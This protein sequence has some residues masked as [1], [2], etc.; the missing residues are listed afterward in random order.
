M[1]LWVAMLAITTFFWIG[2]PIVFAAITVALVLWVRWLRSDRLIVQVFRQAA[3][4]DFEGAV[5][6]LRRAA[7]EDDPRGVRLEALGFL[8]FQRARWPEAADA[9]A[10]S[11]ER[12]A[13]RMIRRVYQAHA[14][15]KSGR[16]DEATSLLAGLSAAAPQD[17]SP[18]CGMAMVLVE[19]GNVAAA[20]EQYW[21]A[22]QILQQHSAR[23]TSDGMGLLEQCAETISRNVSLE[24]P[25][26]DAPSPARQ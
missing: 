13:T 23:Q 19:A 16:L 22:R 25:A 2:T 11:A 21:K 1:T 3:E 5:A 24:P 6:R 14:M 4:G 9:F 26:G 7:S 12:N 10:Q 17:V 15:A 20:A 8:Y 18:V